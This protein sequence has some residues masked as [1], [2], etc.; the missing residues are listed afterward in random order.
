M[1]VVKRAGSNQILTRRNKRQPFPK[2][3]TGITGLS[4]LCL[5]VMLCALLPDSFQPICLF[6]HLSG[7]PCF[8]C[9]STRAAEFLLRGDVGAA[10]RIQPLATAAFLFAVLYTAYLI[11]VYLFRCPCVR[12]KGWGRR[13]RALVLAV[14]AILIVLN[15]CYLLHTGV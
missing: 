4:L 1:A 7:M 6:R 2:F 11:L 12:I 5:A 13:P 10:F 14:G 8:S 3:S 15:W 9:G